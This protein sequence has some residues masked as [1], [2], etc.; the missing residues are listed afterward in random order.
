MK[1]KLILEF[2]EFNAMRMNPDN[3]SQ[4]THV[5]NPSLSLDAYDRFEQNLKSSLVRLNHIYKD[6]SRTKSGFNLRTHSKIDV[7][8]IENIKI[9]RIYKQ[10]DIHYNFYIT[11][12]IG[13]NE[14]YGVIRRFGSN[15]EEFTSEAFSDP[16]LNLSYEWTIRAKGNIIKAIKQWLIPAKGTYKAL[17]DQYFTDVNSGTL[18]YIKEGDTFKLFKSKEDRHFIEFN[19][20]IGELS[21]NF[22][23]YFNYYNIL[24]N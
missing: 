6:I 20:K 23:I 12:E 14:Y 9:L 18:Y 11:F 24:E 13:G 7:V 5:D 17:N 10:D 21:N 8:D 3:L 19:N 4:A 2:T 22:F 1:N 15:R 16:Y